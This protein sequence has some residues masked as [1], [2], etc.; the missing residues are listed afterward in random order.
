MEIFRDGPPLY[1]ISL[2]TPGQRGVVFNDE[3]VARYR[4]G[5]LSLTSN[6]PIREIIDGKAVSSSDSRDA[7]VLGERVRT[8]RFHR[9]T[10]AE[11]EVGDRTI[12]LSGMQDRRTGMSFGVAPVS[13]SDNIVA[14]DDY[15]TREKPQTWLRAARSRR[16]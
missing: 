1:Q 12:S 9:S 6:S 16:G 15:Q 13:G 10:V 4:K 14:L 2:D 3:F 8:R 11:L 7:R 5:H